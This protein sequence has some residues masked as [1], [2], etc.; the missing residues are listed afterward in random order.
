MLE[1]SG[2]DDLAEWLIEKS[3]QLDGHW[4]D[5]MEAEQTGF[6][7]DGSHLQSDRIQ[8]ITA[9]ARNDIKRFRTELAGLQVSQ[10]LDVVKEK[11]GTYLDDWDSFFNH[12][13]KYD[14]SGDLDD[15]GVATRAYKA[16]DV[17]FSGILEALGLGSVKPAEAS[18]YSQ[19][20]QPPAVSLRQ[21]RKKEIIREKEVIVKVKC[22][23]CHQLYNETLD[24]C[25]VVE[26]KDETP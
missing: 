15:L 26:R 24:E 8:S 11:C 25:L 13:S 14:R 5:I 7:P 12:M 20:Q 19:T 18:M 6:K 3:E 10:H 22:P 17:I 21:V 23:Y 2:K 4:Q 1:Y 16:V 9:Q